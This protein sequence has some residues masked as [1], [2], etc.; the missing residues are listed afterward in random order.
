M[1]TKSSA[2]YMDWRARP[3]YYKNNDQ[4]ALN[5]WELLRKDSWGA[6]QSI[7]RMPG[8]FNP[9]MYGSLPGQGDTFSSADT[10]RDAVKPN[11]PRPGSMG[12]LSLLQQMQDPNSPLAGL[13][14]RFQQPAPVP[15]A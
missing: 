5:L 9:A 2:D 15:P 13:L 11:S 14:G 12:L 1:A 7:N 3:E 6:G 10:I 4:G 8:V